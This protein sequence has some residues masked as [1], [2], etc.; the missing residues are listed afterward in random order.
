MYFFNSLFCFPHMIFFF[1]S[2]IASSLFKPLLV[3][4]LI[5][6]LT[7][8]P[9]SALKKGQML[10]STIQYLLF[11]KEKKWKKPKEDPDSFFETVPTGKQP[12]IQRKTIIF[13][14]HGESTWNDT[15]NKGDRPVVSFILN[16]IPNLVKAIFMEWFFFV[17]G[18]SNESWFYDSA[19]S[20]KGIKQALGIQG[21]LKTNPKFA[22]PKEQKMLRLLV[23]DKSVP[24]QLVSSNLRRAISTML[25]GFSDRLQHNYSRDNVLLLA[26]LQEISFNPDAL[27]ITAPREQVI[28]PWTDPKSIHPFYE[29]GR[30]DP[31]MNTGNKRVDGNGLERLQAFC[32][33][34]FD[35]IG[36]DNIIAAGHSLWFKAFFQ[37]YL[38]HTTDHVAKKKK[39]VNGGMCGFTLERIL[40][41]E[42]TKQWAYRIDPTSLVVFHGGF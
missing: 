37:T 10:V 9:S 32:K 5:G 34:A 2:W 1:L 19:L 17:T 40:V 29:K 42:A 35:D 22:T 33:T 23:G 15:F 6:V 28:P 21:F 7:S 11:C 27:S 4:S 3:V 26:E 8:S 25:I 24:A 13:V 12:K 31:G 39:L 41:D 18:E 14:R 16:F 30:V 38:P 20:E 36:K